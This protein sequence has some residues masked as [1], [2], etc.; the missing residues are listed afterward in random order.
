MG[1]NYFLFS[2]QEIPSDQ[3][4]WFSSIFH[5]FSSSLLNAAP[6][7]YSVFTKKMELIPP[8]LCTRAC[9]DSWF[10]SG[11]LLWEGNDLKLLVS[12]LD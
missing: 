11:F 4:S 7:R 5:T 3:I 1:V 2:L 9:R 8:K 12:G 6:L 10:L